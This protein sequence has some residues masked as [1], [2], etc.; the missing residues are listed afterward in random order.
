MR[1]VFV[2]SEVVPFAKT[3]GLADVA[4]ALPKALAAEGI[5]TI[6]FM[7]RYKGIDKKKFNLKLVAKRKR[8][9]LLDFGAKEYNLYSSNLPESNVQI[10]FIDKDKYFNRDELY[11][12][13]GVDYPDN[14]ERFHFFSLAVLDALKSLD[15]KADVIHCNDWQTALIPL[16]LKTM[17]QDNP[18]YKNIATLYTIHNLAYHGLFDNSVLADLNFNSELFTPEILEFWGKVNFAKAGLV[19]AD[20]I[21]TVSETYSHEIQTKEFGM[22]LDGL[23]SKRKNDIYGIINGLDYNVWNPEIDTKIQKKYSVK[24]INDKEE[25]KK[26]LLELNGL[27]YEPG[28]PV[29]GLISRLTDQKGFD[30]LAEILEPM[31]EKNL[32]FVLLGTGDPKYHDLLLDFEKRFPSKLKNNLKFD[33][34]LAQM[35]YAGS[36]IFLMPS[37]FEPCGLGQLISLKYGT[38]P[39]VRKTGGLADTIIDVDENNANGNGYVFT[40]YKSEKLL[41]ALNRALD[42]YFNNPAKWQQMQ[43]QGM[44][45]DFSWDNSAKKYIE[46]YK[47]AKKK[48]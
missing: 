36:D 8:M 5:E 10:Y 22:G 18:F 1:V 44:N 11:Q 32:K 21:S 39:L 38:I 4:G 48:I 20:L 35:I 23:L 9:K 26:K 19:F 2:S 7:P 14:A 15:I 45:A 42:C 29:L 28:V 43:R 13:K 37:Y 34:M 40:E 3:G 17:L 6:V 46:V 47:L 24:N 27:S 41:D 12:V 16:F 31:L 25:N 30:I 33:A